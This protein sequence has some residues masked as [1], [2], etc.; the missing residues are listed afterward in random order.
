[1]KHV[2]AIGPKQNI[3]KEMET[4]THNDDQILIRI[5]YVGVC[6]SEH[7][8]WATAK[9]GDAFGHEPSGVIE[10]IGKNCEGLGY[11]IG[12]RVSGM[13]GNTLPGAGGMV[14]FAAVDPRKDTIIVAPDHIRSEDFILEPLSCLMSAV[15]KAKVDMPGMRVAV[16]GCG[17]MG[18]GAI[19]LLKLRGAHV[20]AIDIRPESIINAQKYGADETY[21]VNEAE[22]KFLNDPSFPGFEVVM[23]WG[24]SGESLD[25]ALRL[26]KMLGQLCIGAYH[27]GGKRLVDIQLLNFNAIEVSNVHPRDEE[28]SVRGAHLATEL[29]SSGKWNY[30]DVPTKVYPR[31]KFDQA[32]EELESKYGKY[33]KSVIDMTWAEGEPYII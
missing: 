25:L 6:M 33:L 26:T 29:L 19:G 32:H 11:T 13:W 16:V 1:M 14:E 2:S 22:K 24:E 28:R 31:N 17:Y 12:D 8:A 15:S 20:T 10:S 9:P 30:V 5:K 23:E 18:C 21:L 3:V 4:V 7:H 27:T